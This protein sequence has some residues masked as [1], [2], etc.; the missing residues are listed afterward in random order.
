MVKNKMKIIFEKRVL[1]RG[2]IHIYMK[3]FDGW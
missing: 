1:K 2:D 3:A